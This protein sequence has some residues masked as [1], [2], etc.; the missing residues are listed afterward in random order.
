MEGDVGREVFVFARRSQPL[1]F[2]MVQEVGEQGQSFR[3]GPAAAC[4]FTWGK[5]FAAFFE[6]LQPTLPLRDQSPRILADIMH[7]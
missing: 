4:K 7:V 5:R 6:A 3:E 2:D 1:K